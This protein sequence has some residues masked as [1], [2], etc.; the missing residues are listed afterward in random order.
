MKLFFIIIIFNII[1]I[2]SNHSFIIQKG[3]KNEQNIRDKNIEILSISYDLL[4]DLNF[5]IKVNIKTNNIINNRINFIAFLKKENNMDDYTLTCTDVLKDMITCFPIKNYEFE[6]GSK[7]YFY[8]DIRKSNSSIL[9]NGKKIYEDYNKISL[10]FLPI[11]IPNQILYKDKKKFKVI[12]QNNLISKGYLYLTKKFKKVLN[13][14]KSGFNKYIELNNYIPRGGLSEMPSWTS[15]AYKEAIRRGYKMVDGDLLFTKDK[16]PV[17]AHDIDLKNVCNGNGELIA[18]T[19]KELEKYDFGIKY[20]KKYAGEKILKFEDLLKLCKENNIIIDMDLGHLNYTEFFNNKEEYIKIIIDYVDRY[21]MINSIIFNDKRQDILDIFNS[22]RKDLSFSINGMNEKDNIERIKN[23]YNDSKIL[24]YN[25]GG[26]QEGKK[27]NKDA[28]KYGISLGKKIKA[29]KIDNL[30]FAN[31]IISWGVNFICTYNLEPFLMKNEKEEPILV[32]CSYY[33]FNHKITIC[34]IDEYIQLKD[35]E[36]YN[37]YYSTNIYN[38]SE[39]IIEVPIG[40]IKYIDT[41][42]TNNL[43][44]DIYFFDFESGIIRLNTSKIVNKHTNII[45]TLGPDYENVALCYQYNYICHG[46]DNFSLECKINKNDSTK[47]SFRGNYSI[48]SLNGYSYNPIM[49]NKKIKVEKCFIISKLIFF[50]LNIFILFM[51]KI[52]CKNIFYN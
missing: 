52:K 34:E 22:L 27:I 12:I 45:G 35:N 38:I 4:Y 8:Y 10:I 19:L 49:M 29:A 36:F 50:M 46:N 15:L 17:V 41:M 31:K 16:I 40:D 23:K 9:I 24:I 33:D 48:Y 21:D 32:N 14:P 18:K 3:I 37:I 6:K 26:L 43:F 2:R 20:N 42:S 51:L 30:E 5:I 39:D 1:F 44:Y 11:I 7:Y 25:M 13:K 28:V 47:I